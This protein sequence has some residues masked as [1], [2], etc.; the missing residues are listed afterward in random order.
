MCEG[1]GEKV[2]IKKAALY[3]NYKLYGRT[4]LWCMY[5]SN[6][7]TWGQMEYWECGFGISLSNIRKFC[8][9]IKGTM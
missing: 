8:S 3:K 7:S 6:Y 5:Y 1:Q 4:S 2:K 9:R